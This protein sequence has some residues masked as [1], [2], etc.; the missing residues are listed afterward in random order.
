MI[1][2]VLLQ[3]TVPDGQVQTTQLATLSTPADAPVPLIKPLIVKSQSGHEYKLIDK[4]TGGHLKGQKLLRSHLN[5]QVLVEDQ[6]VL[7]LQ[8]Y[9]FVGIT[10]VPDASVYKLQ[11]QACEEV[12]VTSHLSQETLNVPESMVW[13]ENNDALDCKVTLLNSDNAMVSL[14][15][16]PTASGLGLADI[17]GLALGL[18][19]LSGGGKDTPVTP[20]PTPT[21]TPP[22]PAPPPVIPLTTIKSLA[23]T[24][25]TGEM[26][27]RLN[28]GDTLTATITFSDIVNLNTQ[29]GSPTLQLLVGTQS[30][31]AR[32]VSGSGSNTLVFVTTIVNG[33]TDLDGVAIANNALQL[34]GAMLQNTLGSSTLNTSSAVLSNPS[35]MVDTTP[36]IAKLEAGSLTLTQTQSGSLQ[37]QSNELGKAYVV[38]QSSV[39]FNLSDL[40]N[41]SPLISKSVAIDSI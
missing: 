3:I 25:A 28:V 26:N 33:Q 2:I 30:V 8:D 7:T 17:S 5:L 18:M 24:S 36:P 10:P 14:P 29:A 34:N 31:E 1:N 12:Q 38:P 35:Y 4:E 20:T 37:V 27:H 6:V 16:L 19:A 22:P 32:Y 9:F 11:N 15:T 39:I 13:T 23:L 40:E 21:P 41:L